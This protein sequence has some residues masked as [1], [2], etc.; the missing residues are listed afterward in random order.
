MP[1]EDL[2]RAATRAEGCE[3]I[4]DAPR[5]GS[6]GVA[7]R[8]AGGTGGSG[9]VTAFHGLF[10]DAWLSCSVETSGAVPVP[11]AEALDRAGRWCA[12]VLQAAA[13]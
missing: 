13:A 11:P 1:A 7:V 3:P 10:G 6:L 9:V 12:T 5:F 4:A 2:R 8:C